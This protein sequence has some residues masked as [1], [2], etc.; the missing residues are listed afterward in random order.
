MA[1]RTATGSGL[2]ATQ[3]V[4]L[5]AWIATK[6]DEYRADANAY[7]VRGDANLASYSTGQ[8]EALRM[9]ERYILDHCDHDA[10]TSVEIVPS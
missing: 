10:V 6:V 8:V 1:T 3:L 4:E 2:T 9:A 7:R 5:L